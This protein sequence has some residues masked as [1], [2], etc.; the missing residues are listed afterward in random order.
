MRACASSDSATSIK[1]TVKKNRQSKWMGIVSKSLDTTDQNLSQAIASEYANL[2]FG[3]I[4][5]I[6]SVEIPPNVSKVA[7]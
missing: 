1:P 5:P 4:K 6:N 2:P 3:S 7:N